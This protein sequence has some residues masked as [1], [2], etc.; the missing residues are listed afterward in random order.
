[1]L[2]KRLWYCRCVKLSFLH[3]FF[4]FF[5]VL[6]IV[7]PS[8]LSPPS[9]LWCPPMALKQR[10]FMQCEWKVFFPSGVQSVLFVGLTSRLTYFSLRIYSALSL[11]S[12]C[13]NTHNTKDKST[14]VRE[15]LYFH[16]DNPVFCPFLYS[17]Y[18]DFLSS[19][20]LSLLVPLWVIFS[21]N[22]SSHLFP[23]FFSGLF[24]V[25]LAPASSRPHCS[26][27]SVQRFS[28]EWDFLTNTGETTMKI[29]RDI[30]HSQ[31]MTT[32]HV[33]AAARSSFPWYKTLIHN[34]SS[35]KGILRFPWNLPWICMI[36]FL[37]FR[38]PVEGFTSRV[39]FFCFTW[40]HICAPIWAPG[41]FA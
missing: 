32:N 38:L 13:N 15:N 39:F 26:V 28:P 4:S 22:A 1:M 9:C 11:I 36:I 29:V 6:Y 18:P 40:V 25:F 14:L 3:H 31:I 34:K 8:I 35:G 20:C 12:A 41:L 7:Q 10:I 23:L 2:I 24:F 21:L 27:L 30:L 19:P 33:G 5:L 37:I 16:F 17:T